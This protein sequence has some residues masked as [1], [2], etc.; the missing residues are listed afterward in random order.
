M[1]EIQK[2]SNRLPGTTAIGQLQ[3]AA[4]QKPDQ[5]ATSVVSAGLALDED[6]VVQGGLPADH[7]LVDRAV[8][9]TLEAIKAHQ[10]IIQNLE[11]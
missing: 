9:G 4:N 5:A 7:R 8:A 2:E 10:L 1:S 11:F 3:L 6:Y